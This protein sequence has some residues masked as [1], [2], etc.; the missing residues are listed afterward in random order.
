MCGVIKVNF[1]FIDDSGQLLDARA[2][3]VGWRQTPVTRRELA[4]LN[5]FLPRLLVHAFAS[6]RTASTTAA[7]WVNGI[8]CAAPRTTSVAARNAGAS[9]LAVAKGAASVFSPTRIV[10][11]GGDS[12]RS[13]SPVLSDR[14]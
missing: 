5:T 9:C 6:L 8:M 10:V 13:A 14:A 1:G 12:A 4:V 11:G 2:I 7:G 3:A